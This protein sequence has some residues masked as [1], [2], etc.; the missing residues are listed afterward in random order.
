MKTYPKKKPQQQN[1]ITGGAILALIV[2]M[3]FIQRTGLKWLENWW[4]LLFLIP[5]IA[6]V[7]NIFA[8]VQK[9]K[10]FSF[11]LASNIV[12][13]IFP[14]AIC[15][16]FLLALDW[17]TGLPIIIM[18]AGFSMLLIGFVKDSGG[19]G[20]IIGVLRAWLFSWGIAVI[21]IGIISLVDS[22]NANVSTQIIF[23][24][25][26]YALMIAAS[27]GL[28]SAWL[29]F[30]FTGKPTSRVLAHLIASFIIAFPGI[31]A[32]TGKSF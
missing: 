31:M 20:K 8:E 25:Y 3:V 9:R 12:G 4:A 30:R 32:I 6:S 2:I 22:M 11:S 13:V 28:V 19:S 18:L 23:K 10:G 24:W 7:N 21:V 14:V 17:N 5:A 29:D 15:I 1:R 26:G 16:I 27:G